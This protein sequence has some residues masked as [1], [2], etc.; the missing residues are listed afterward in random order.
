MYFGYILKCNQLPISEAV[1]II[2]MVI[3]YVIYKHNL[4]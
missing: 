1:Y 2:M 4:Q 3:D